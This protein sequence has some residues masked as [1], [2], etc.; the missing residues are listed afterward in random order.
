MSP[1]TRGHILCP[2]VKTPSINLQ[3]TL[4][5]KITTTVRTDRWQFGLLAYART[6]YCTYVPL[7]VQCLVLRT[8]NRLGTSL[9]RT[10]LVTGTWYP[11]SF[12]ARSRDMPIKG[13]IPLV[14]F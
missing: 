1:G 10:V 9:P 8:T 7:G 11:C 12:L 14:E 5:L 4:L 13:Y 6:M 2:L 3:Y